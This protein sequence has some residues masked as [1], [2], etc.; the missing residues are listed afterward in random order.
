[1][2]QRKNGIKRAPDART[3]DMGRKVQR[4][5]RSWLGLLSYFMSSL[6]LQLHR[7]RGGLVVR[8]LGLPFRRTGFRFPAG[9]LPGF[10]GS[11]RTTPLPVRAKQ[12]ELE[13]HRNAR[14]G[15]N[16]RS[17][18]K[19]A[20]PRHRPARSPLAKIK[21]ILIRDLKDWRE[22]LGIPRKGAAVA[23]W[24]AYSPPTKEIRAQCPAGSL[25]IFA[26]GNRAR[27]C[28][29]SV[30]LLGDLPF[31][32]PPHS[33]ALIGSQ[34]L[35]VK[36]RPNLFTHSITRCTLG[37]IRATGVGR[38]L[39]FPAQRTARGR[40]ARAPSEIQ[41]NYLVL[42]FPPPYNN[43]S[44]SPP[45]F[46]IPLAGPFSLAVTTPLP[47]K[48]VTTVRGSIVR[49]TVINGTCQYDLLKRDWPLHR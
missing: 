26:C 17:P 23:E 45:P 11:C 1:M 36:S 44:P 25:Q 5:P 9:S 22:K 48:Q 33:G 7:G 49:C 41:W 8:L 35:D 12:G 40:N 16:G 6:L 30:G 31:R 10:S 34:D 43:G 28:R 42:P 37:R 3:D 29:C 38:C 24:L 39:V 27:R 2:R 32:L 47:Y 4:S 20:E 46:S 19:P 18:R 15:G 14:T 21:S 13:Q